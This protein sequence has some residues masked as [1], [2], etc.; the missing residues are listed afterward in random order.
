MQAS[1]RMLYL[2]IMWLM[3][4]LSYAVPLTGLPVTVSLWLIALHCPSQASNPYFPKKH[5]IIAVSGL[6]FPAPPRI[7]WLV[8][9]LIAT[10]IP[11]VAVWLI[12]SVAS[13]AVWRT[14][15]VTWPASLIRFA[16]DKVSET[17]TVKEAKLAQG[18]SCSQKFTFGNPCSSVNTPCSGMAAKTP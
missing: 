12:A 11:S 6:P 5:N 8:A 1:F 14:D 2:R 17:D 16:L 18:L 4:P 9:S 7:L 3:R 10:C 15:Q 13:V